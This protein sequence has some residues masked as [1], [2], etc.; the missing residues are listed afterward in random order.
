MR[1][2]DIKIIFINIENN[3]TIIKNLHKIILANAS[4]L[5]DDMMSVDSTNKSLTFTFENKKCIENAEKVIDYIYKKSKLDIDCIYFILKY[6]F[7]E[8]A[9]YILSNMNTFNINVTQIEQL[10]SC[11]TKNYLWNPNKECALRHRILSEMFKD[12]TNFTDS[13]DKLYHEFIERIDPT[14]LLH[15]IKEYR[16]TNK[17]MDIA[18]VLVCKWFSSPYVTFE[19]SQ[20]TQIVDQIPMHSLSRCLRRYWIENIHHMKAIYKYEINKIVNLIEMKD[21]PTFDFDNIEVTDSY[22]CK[23]EDIFNGFLKQSDILHTFYHLVIEYKNREFIIRLNG[24]NRYISEKVYMDAEIECNIILGD[25]G[26][27]WITIKG[28]IN[29]NQEYII[30]PYDLEDFINDHSEFNM[31]HSTYIALK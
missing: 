6:Q 12:C 25:P 3:D 14:M 9:H 10:Y 23:R 29:N 20:V 7:H 28:A 13:N 2:S 19:Q 4:E 21:G 8:C 26:P 27:Q 30:Y 22:T 11:A 31:R 17:C 15:L 5:L 24:M 1:Y 16:D 18:S